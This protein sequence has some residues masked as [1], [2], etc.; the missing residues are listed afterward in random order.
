MLFVRVG[1]AIVDFSGEEPGKASLLKNIGNIILLTTMEMVSETHVFAEKSGLG[2]ANLQKLLEALL[3][4]GPA[5]IYSRGMSSGRYYHE[6]V[7]FL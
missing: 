4:T 1:R 7:G 5:L 6:S 2:V 3:P